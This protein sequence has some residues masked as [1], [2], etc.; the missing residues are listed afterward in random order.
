M[1][2]KGKRK[3][4]PRPRRASEPRPRIAIVG[5]GCAGLAAAWQLSKSMC[6]VH[7]Y[8][9]NGYLGGKGASFRDPS[10]GRIK[11]HGLHVWLGFYENAFRMMRECYAEVGDR[12]WG[13]HQTDPAKRLVHGSFDDAFAPE[14]HIGV[15]VDDRAGGWEVWSGHLPPMKGGPGEPIDEDSNPFTLANYLLRCLE[16]IK[17]LMLS[18]VEP[19]K[20][21]QPGAPLGDQ[22]SGLDEEMELD[23]SFDPV[24]SPRALIE[25]MARM[26]RTGVL[27]TAAGVLQGVTIAE[28]WVRTLNFA[29]QVSGT[30]LEF[31]LALAAQTRKQL[32]DFVSID[33]R[34]R[35]K[36]EVIDIVMTIAVG[37]YR[38]KVL[39]SRD[40][41]DSINGIDYR[42][43]LKKHGATKS[44][45]ESPFLTGIYD[46][47]FAYR[48]GDRK[49]PALAAGVALRGA[50]RMFFT[51]RGAMF[52]RMRSG[53]GDA[54]FAPLYRVMSAGRPKSEA[55]EDLPERRKVTF[56]FSHELTGIDFDLDRER[57]HRVAGLRFEVSSAGPGG[58]LDDYGCWP[59]SGGADGRTKKVEL[60]ADTDFDAVIFALGVDD[61]VRACGVDSVFFEALP[62]WDMMR[63]HVRTT[64]TKAAQVWFEAEP[65]KLGW[66]RAPG[67]ITALGPPFDTWANMTHTISS[68]RAWCDARGVRQDRKHAAVAYL[69]GTLPEATVQRI[70]SKHAAPDLPERTLREKVRRELGQMIEA[71]VEAVLPDLTRH[72]I[73]AVLQQLIE[74][75]MAQ[76]VDIYGKDGA[77]QRHDLAGLIARELAGE[78]STVALSEIQQAVDQL[79]GAS[80]HT[81]GSDYA[82]SG[83]DGGGAPAADDVAAQIADELIELFGAGGRR[84][85]ALHE[86][87]A[88]PVETEKHVQANF[89]GS[90]RYT[91][92]LP[93]SIRFR[94]SPLE[95]SVLNMT[96]AGDWTACGLD[97]GCV[98]A[99]VMSGM[100]AAHAITREPALDDIVGYHHP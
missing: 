27:A 36:T 81:I 99:A 40:G 23:F 10:S 63:K 68:E 73:Q 21:A 4:E 18:V 38:D 14:P 8:E 22:R 94:I 82:T 80:L 6:E 95:R 24:R 35:W 69:C 9:R 93:G 28:D 62:D 16:L 5:G 45:V 39:F 49:R 59:E 54:V 61:F 98:E 60:K 34:L 78:A 12:G 47:V 90:E 37:L 66:T 50:L 96:I 85:S 74:K 86:L 48:D 53:M 7:V 91:L 55:T 41:L 79:V 42:R 43:W 33:P 56:H 77:R 46:L 1:A 88:E 71:E 13:P 26:L 70:K 100:L 67:L 15:A 75:E 19:I 44:A 64:A 51:Y 29:P 89:E 31:L 32:R 30:A 83:Q 3:G 2:T 52:W 11:E 97:A 57:G 72:R 87:F 84:K 17:A 65:A 20:G 76:T 92:A 25:R 58:A